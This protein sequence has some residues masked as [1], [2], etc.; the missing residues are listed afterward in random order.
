M[1]ATDIPL[2]V[3]CWIM[4]TIIREKEARGDSTYLLRIKY[5]RVDAKKALQDYL[6][7]NKTMTQSPKKKEAYVKLFCDNM[8]FFLPERNAKPLAEWLFGISIRNGY[9][10]E[11]PQIWA[12][13]DR[14][15]VISPTIMQ[16][17]PGPKKKA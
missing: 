17:R 13:E 4:A 14:E 9:L 16:D 12:G 8:L 15:Y 7:Y 3:I 10:S 5:G 1:S 2:P 11:V 6:Q